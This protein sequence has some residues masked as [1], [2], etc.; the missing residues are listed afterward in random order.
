MKQ[1]N[2]DGSFWAALFTLFFSAIMLLLGGF[3]LVGLVRGEF[4]VSNMDMEGSL[5]FN[6]VKSLISLLVASVVLWQGWREARKRR[7]AGV[8]WWQPSQKT[9]AALLVFALLAALPFGLSIHIDV[10]TPPDWMLL[11]A[12]YLLAAG[13]ILVVPCFLIYSLGKSLGER[14]MEK[15]ERDAAKKF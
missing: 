4:L 13:L 11:Y 8:K 7:P 2:T 5:L 10:D 6:G 14:D 12:L 1:K 3:I 9:L 15:G